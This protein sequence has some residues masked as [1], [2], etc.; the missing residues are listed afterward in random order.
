MVTT[1]PMRNV[2]HKPELSGQLDKWAV[3]MSEFDIEHK[4]KTTIKSKVLA[5]F[6][7][8]FS[9][10]L[11]LLATKEMMMVSKKTSEV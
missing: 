9:P 6:V 2:L 7:A 11:L 5:D 10:R 3:E 8:N 1:F 4:S